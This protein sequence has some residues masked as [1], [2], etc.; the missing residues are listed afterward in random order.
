MTP[1]TVK[2]TLREPQGP[3]LNNL[4]MFVFVFSS[5]TALEANGLDSCK[6]PVGTG[7][8]KFVEWLPNEQVTLVAN[9]NY[10]DTANMAKTPNVIV[11][12]IPNNSSRL[13]ALSAGEIQGMEG[14]EPRDVAAIESNPD[15][16]LILRPANTTGYVA[17]NYN[18]E[19]FNDPKVREAFATAINKAAI[20][21]AFYGGTGMV[22]N[23]F[24]PPALWGY[25]PDIVD[26][27]FD[28]EA[29]KQLLVDAG[30]PDG[31]SEVTFNG[32]ESAAGVLVHAGLATL[33]PEPQGH[34]HRH[35]G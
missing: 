19:E 18:V 17:F 13:L 5:P 2:I 34:R 15:F 28:T 27:T 33:L 22:A 7:P 12:N 3:F 9:E 31:I 35:R 24:Q 6:N 23:Q 20:V 10:W 1:T 26:R 14:M 16:K 4:A 21:D 29:A 11:R 32:A 25:N 30:F 8:Y